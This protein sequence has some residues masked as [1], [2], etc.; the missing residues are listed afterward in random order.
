MKPAEAAAV[1]KNTQPIDPILLRQQEDEDNAQK[2]KRQKKARGESTIDPNDPKAKN[3][4]IVREAVEMTKRDL[5]SEGV[6]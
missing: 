3:K 1:K 5:N 6:L 2:E 4:A